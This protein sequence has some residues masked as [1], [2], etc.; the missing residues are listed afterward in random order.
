MRVINGTR[1]DALAYARRL[2]QETGREH[3]IYE[4]A[5]VTP[6]TVWGVADVYPD[7]TL[8]QVERRHDITELVWGTLLT[9]VRADSSI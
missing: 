8:S 9:F 5:L 2:A 3:W 7:E 4:N 1:R 6:A